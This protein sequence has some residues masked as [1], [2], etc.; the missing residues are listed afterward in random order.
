M[1]RL[2][3]P[4]GDGSIYV[5]D[6]CLFPL[7]IR[8]KN[9]KDINVCIHL[10]ISNTVYHWKITRFLAIY[11][12]TKWLILSIFFFLEIPPILLVYLYCYSSI[13]IVIQDENGCKNSFWNVKTCL[14]EKASHQLTQDLVLLWFMKTL[15]LLFLLASHATCW[16]RWFTRYSTANRIS[17]LRRNYGVKYTSCQSEEGF[18]TNNLQGK[19]YN[20]WDDW[21]INR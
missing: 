4:Y 7:H 1:W 20:I 10:S 15:W 12:T 13:Y 11:D 8:C 9:A 19:Y 16:W 18:Y 21:S 14:T 6:Q 2:C 5:W 17:I 3:L